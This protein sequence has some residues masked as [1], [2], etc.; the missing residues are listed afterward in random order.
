[1]VGELTLASRA[2]FARFAAG[3]EI[4]FQLSP[5]ML[6]LRS[7]FVLVAGGAS[8]WPRFRRALAAHLTSFCV[9]SELADP[10]RFVA[11]AACAKE[12]LLL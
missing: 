10:E 8:V 6:E 12:I 11:Q 3:V 4:S 1:M 5:A 9:F 2:R 7:R